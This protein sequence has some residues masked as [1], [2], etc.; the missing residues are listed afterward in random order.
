MAKKT[1]KERGSEILEYRIEKEKQ[2][3]KD[4]KEFGISQHKIDRI[5]AKQARHEAEKSCS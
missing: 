5:E 3:A 1:K 4:W 2:L